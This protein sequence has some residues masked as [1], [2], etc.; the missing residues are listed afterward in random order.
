MKQILSNKPIFLIVAGNACN[1]ACIMCSVKSHSKNYPDGTTKEIIK[2]LIKGIKENYERMEFTGGEPTI[3]KDILLLIKQARNLGYKEIGINTNGILLGNKSFCEK[4]VKAGLTNITFSLHAHNKKLHK[5]ITRIPNS[6]EQTVAGIKNALN[7]KNLKVSVVTVILKLNY[8]HIFEVGKFIHSL[9]VPFWDIT[10]LI[11]DGYAKESYD[12]LCVKRTEL[13]KA[14][15]SLRPLLND[16]QAIIFFAFSPCIFPPDILNNKSVKWVTALG[17]LKVEKPIRYNQ[18]NFSNNFVE[19]NSTGLQ[20]KKIDICQNCIF[21][22]ECAG[23]WTDYLRLY[24][25]EEIRK[26]AVKHGCVNRFN[27]E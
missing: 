17:K 6:F 19:K 20:Q 8:Q 16:S 25:D 15:C 24:G 4:L 23:T 22:K 13:S 27:K 11:P 9:G 14:L 1:S 3:R 12:A 7:Y 10:D 18:K 2:D 5:I 26:L 21:T